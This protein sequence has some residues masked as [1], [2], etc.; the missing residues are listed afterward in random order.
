MGELYAQL[1]GVFGFR[2]SGPNKTQSQ[3]QLRDPIELLLGPKAKA[4]FGTPSSSSRGKSGGM[5]LIQGAQTL[6]KGKLRHLVRPFVHC[7]QSA[8]A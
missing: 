8:S 6:P 7:A 3:S 2:D 5:G 4:D 1:M